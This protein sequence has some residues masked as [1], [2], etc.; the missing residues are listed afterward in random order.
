M[1]VIGTQTIARNI[2]S[3]D[4]FTNCTPPPNF[5]PMTHVAGV[6]T[7]GIHVGALQGEVSCTMNSTVSVVD[8]EQTLMGIAP[9][10]SEQRAKIEATMLQL[11]FANLQRIL[12][13]A[14]PLAASGINSLFMGGNVYVI[15]VCIVVIGQ[16]AG[17]NQYAEF[18]LYSACQQES[19]AMEISK[20]GVR[21]VKVTFEGYMDM[22]R[23]P[24]DRLCQVV[25]DAI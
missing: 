20:A 14:T 11:D 4:L 1:P 13:Q 5:T 23:A 15:P 12:P 22:S 2:V 25:V 9:H 8:T 18:V 6:P 3:A 7:G 24:G 19:L 17:T 16:L 21:T 10:I